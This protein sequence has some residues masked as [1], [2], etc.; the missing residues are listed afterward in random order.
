VLLRKEVPKR[1]IQTLKVGDFYEDGYITSLQKAGHIVSIITSG[2]NLYNAHLKQGQ[3]TVFRV[4][5]Y[6]RRMERNAMK[7]DLRT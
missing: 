6:R 7:R 5:R 2:G 4:D 1:D 3:Y